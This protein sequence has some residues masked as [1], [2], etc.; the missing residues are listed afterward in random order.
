MDLFDPENVKSVIVT[1]NT[2]SVKWR[3]MYP[4]FEAWQAEIAAER[5]K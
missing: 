3:E 2:P 1:V 4:G 5:E